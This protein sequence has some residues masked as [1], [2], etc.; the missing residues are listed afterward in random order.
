MEFE[1]HQTIEMKTKIESQFE[2]IFRFSNTVP[3]SDV[4]GR[5][6]NQAESGDFSHHQ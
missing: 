4:N 1:G 5:K 2:S 3:T 6:L